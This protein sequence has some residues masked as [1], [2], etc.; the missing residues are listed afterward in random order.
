MQCNC[1]QGSCLSRVAQSCG[2]SSVFTT[3]QT[4]SLHHG[5]QSSSAMQQEWCPKIRS[6]PAD[7]VNYV[8]RRTSGDDQRHENAADIEVRF[9][10]SS[11][12]VSA[13]MAGAATKLICSWPLHRS[14]GSSHPPAGNEVQE[15][16][17]SNTNWQNNAI[18]YEYAKESKPVSVR[19]LTG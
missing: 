11:S 5:F 12:A 15:H 2:V 3:C 8:R 4:I 18:M 7:R 19:V 17:P 6:F 16:S 14:T 9:S 1:M 13:Q 10:P